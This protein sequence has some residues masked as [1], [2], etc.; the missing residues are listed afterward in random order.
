MIPMF[1]DRMRQQGMSATVKFQPSGV[2]GEQYKT[3]LALDLGTRRRPGI[4]SL[5]GIW[6][7]PG[8]EA[9]G[10]LQAAR[11]RDLAVRSACTDRPAGVEWR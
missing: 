1:T 5:D 8:A 2:A 4:V 7:R 11:T 9:P 10:Y 6:A 3:R